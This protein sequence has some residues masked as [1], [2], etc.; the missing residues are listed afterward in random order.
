MTRTHRSSPSLL[1]DLCVALALLAVGLRILIPVGFM[2]G[3]AAHGQGLALVLC[4]GEGPLPF[5]AADD[6][7]G[8]PGKAS[9]DG[10][11]V[12]AAQGAAGPEPSI[13]PVIA[14]AYADGEPLVQRPQ[15][16]LAPGRGLAA[17]PLPARGPPILLS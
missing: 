6:K 12:F 8:A 15:T 2:P 7:G 3:Q 11:C 17:P 1:R 16:D 5:N 14:V 10:A 4:T 9:H 13:E